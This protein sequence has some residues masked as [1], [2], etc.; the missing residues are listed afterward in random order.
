MK[1]G[2]LTMKHGDFS[3]LNLVIEKKWWFETTNLTIIW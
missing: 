3:K 1:H 2:D